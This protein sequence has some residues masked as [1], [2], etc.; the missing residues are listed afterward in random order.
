MLSSPI[1]SSQIA[2]DTIE[3]FD[4]HFMGQQAIS[5]PTRGT[6]R[7]LITFSLAI[8]FINFY[9]VPMQDLEL[10]GVKLP[11]DS[12]YFVIQW[13][14][15]LFVLISHIINWYG[16]H[17]ARK[18]WNIADKVTSTAGFGSDTALVTRLDSIIRIVKDGAGDKSEDSVAII[19]DR[20]DEIKYDALKL[21]SYAWW[22]VYIWHLV[23][24]VV[25]SIVALC[26]S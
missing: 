8:W 12:S 10:N 5:R 19:I 3:E 25:F 18:G 6:G 4:M 7:I 22:Y 14:V 26:W 15:M 21:N 16:D 13:V 24:P 9:N 1:L 2:K 20:L 17:V 23:I 11:Q